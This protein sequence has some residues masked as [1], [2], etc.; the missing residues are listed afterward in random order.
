METTQQIENINEMV[1]VNTKSS[2]LDVTFQ[3]LLSDKSNMKL[4]CNRNKRE[5]NPERNCVCACTHRTQNQKHGEFSKGNENEVPV[6]LSQ[7]SHFFLPGSWTV[8][9]QKHYCLY[10]SNRVLDISPYTNEF[11]YLI[12]YFSTIQYLSNINCPENNTDNLT[13]RP[14][15]NLAG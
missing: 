11:Y 8:Y 14:E 2:C 7:R 12:I 5:K 3:F 6:N 9:N 4:Y 1:Q 10:Q 15:R 13:E